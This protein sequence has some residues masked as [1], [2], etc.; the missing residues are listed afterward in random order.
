MA[1]GVI[2]LV[3]VPIGNLGDITLRAI[4][5]LKAADLIACEDTRKTSFLLS[6]YKIPCPKLISFHKFNERQREDV[7]FEHV[8]MGKDLVVVSDAG[9]PGISDPCEKLVTLAVSQGIQVIAL[10]GASALIPAIT[11]SGFPTQHFQFAGFMPTEAHKRRS[12]ILEISMYPYPTVIYE[13]PHRI[14]EH[15]IELKEVCGNRKVYLCREISKM[16]EE[17]IS[18][19][20]ESLIENRE[21][22]IK[23]EFVVVLEGCEPIETYIGEFKQTDINYHIYK[24]L[25]SGMGTR[26]ISM[27]IAGVFNLTRSNAYKMVLDYLKA[28]KR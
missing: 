24:C 26:E 9:S 14:L 7:L 16:H 17:H 28:A 10:P 23:G 3:P 2:Y 15:L 21:L 4:D 8:K 18:G 12:K 19:T 5:T 1:H 25:K 22:T 27:E 6:Q 11:T 20:L 13:A